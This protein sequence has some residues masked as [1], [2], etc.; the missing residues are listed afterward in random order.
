MKTIRQLLRQPMKTIMGILLAALAAAVLCISV[1]QSIS[2]GQIQ[3]QV[4]DHYSTQ[5]IPSIAYTKEADTWAVQYA[6]ENPEVVTRVSS[7]GLISGYLPE[8]VPDSYT[9][10]LGLQKSL[11][12][13]HLYSSSPEYVTEYGHAVLEFRL[14][15]IGDVTQDYRILRGTILQVIEMNETHTDPTGYNVQ[16]HWYGNDVEL[17]IGGTYLLYTDSY[18]DLDWKLRSGQSQQLDGL[19]QIMEPQPADRLSILDAYDVQNLYFGAAEGRYALST[20]RVGSLT[21]KY[22]ISYLS[23]GETR[24]S[25]E[26]EILQI[27]ERDLYSFRTVFCTVERADLVSLE[28]DARVFLDSPAGAA[29]QKALSELEVNNHAYPFLGVDSLMDIQAYTDNA[30]S[31]PQGRAFTEEELSQGVKVCLISAELAELNGLKVGDIISP[32]FYERDPDLGA[33][34]TEGFGVINPLAN[35]YDSETCRLAEAE[36]YTVVGIYQQEI[37]RESVDRNLYTFTPNT[38]FVPKASVEAEMDHSHMGLFRTFHLVNEMAGTFSQAAEAAGFGQAFV[39]NDHDYSAIESGLDAYS[40][41]IWKMLAVGVGAYILLL[42]LLMVLF[43]GQQGKILRT[44]DSLGARRSARIRH[45]LVSNLFMF[46]PGSALGIWAGAFLWDEISNGL[47]E[48][49]SEALQV[50]VQPELLIGVGAVHII[51]LIAIVLGC[52][53]FLTREQNLLN[54]R[55]NFGQFDDPEKRKAVPALAVIALGAVFSLALCGL[56]SM[57]NEEQRNYEEISQAVPVYLTITDLTGTVDDDLYVSDTYWDALTQDTAWFDNRETLKRFVNQEE[58]I[59][60]VTFWKTPGL[61]IDGTNVYDMQIF[62]ISCQEA[63]SHLAQYSEEVISWFPGYGME[64]L[65]SNEFVCVIPRDLMPADRAEPVTMTVTT[66]HTE[67]DQKFDEETKKYYRVDRS[68]TQ[69]YGFT[70][71]GVHDAGDTVIYCPAESIRQLEDEWY[72]S[73]ENNG[74]PVVPDS[75]VSGSICKLAGTDIPA[76]YPEGIAYMRVSGTLA[77]NFLL[78]S[79]WDVADNWFA[80]PNRLGRRTVWPNPFYEEFPHYDYALRIDDDQFRAVQM[81]LFSNVVIST[82][83][84]LII[85]ALS[86]AASYLIAFLMIRAKRREIMLMRTLG[87]TPEQIYQSFVKEQMSQ[88]LKGVAIGGLIFLWQAPLQLGA[89]IG[90]FFLGLRTALNHFLNKNLM[91]I[92]KEDE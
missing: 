49:A 32:R 84:T 90:I 50:E 9:T 30:L 11:N 82:V 86:V 1:G 36:S 70:V 56:Q 42:G 4:T 5:A 25:E 52:G 21:A 34:I 54:K 24:T 7:P 40:G 29:W 71:V 67:P 47:L 68:F 64:T 8:T 31:F 20:E 46:L 2:A 22:E 60:K 48:G 69:S 81:T 65:Q 16:I 45:I 77:D 55:G 33:G 61:A 79:V 91:T 19:S 44:M 28:S 38:I 78:D 57:H 51:V 27:T 37:V 12:E 63:D 15:Q 58:M 75:V 13:N 39:L 89:L 3:Q 35:P 92:Q 17:E 18:T 26:T 59:Y 41:N 80:R 73:E 87:A 53:I 62:G 85:F 23:G 66:Y 72:R 6:R 43:P 14:D 88:F 83:C 74:F 76:I 10:H